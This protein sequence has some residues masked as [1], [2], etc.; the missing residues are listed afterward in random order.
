MFFSEISPNF[1]VIAFSLILHLLVKGTFIAAI[2]TSSWDQFCQHFIQCFFKHTFFYCYTLILQITLLWL[3]H[4]Y[5]GWNKKHKKEEV[6]AACKLLIKWTLANRFLSR[7]F[8]HFGKEKN[9]FRPEKSSIPPL[10]IL[11]SSDLIE[12]TAEMT[13]KWQKRVCEKEKVV[14]DFLKQINWSQIKTITSCL[15]TCEKKRNTFLWKATLNW[16]KVLVKDSDS[17]RSRIDKM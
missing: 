4:Q 10:S 6:K 11:P 8:L 15:R 9:S 12:L 3:T 1:D 7:N 16:L 5:L 13:E 14:L 17:T 2:N